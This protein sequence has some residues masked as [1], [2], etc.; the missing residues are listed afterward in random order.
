VLDAAVQTVNQLHRSDQLDFAVLTGDLINNR[1]ANELDWLVTTL[2]GGAVHPDSGADDNPL[3]GLDPHDPFVAEGLAIPWYATLGNHDRL[4][5]GHMATDA[6]IGS[7]T[8][9]R[10]RFAV[11]A[12]CV[13]TEMPVRC[14]VAHPTA[15]F[16]AIPRAI[17]ADPARRG[18]SATEVMNAMSGHGFTDGGPGYWSVKPAPKVRLIGLDTS[19][20]DG[21]TGRLDEVQ[22]AFVEAELTLADDLGEVAI[23]TSHHPSTG[24]GKWGP[25]LRRVLHRHDAVIL[26]LAGH[27]HTHSVMP[28]PGGGHGYWEVLTASLLDWPQQF[29]LVEVV[30]TG[31]GVGEIRLTVVDVA[32]TSSVV[33]DAK[34]YALHTSESGPTLFPVSGEGR[35][36]DRNV[37]LRVSLGDGFS[38]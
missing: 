26:H 23:I 14:G 5:E 9:D 33:A 2:E 38:M 10:A 21:L 20:D 13:E 16:T 22:L 29:R 35:A 1:Q 12:T 34:T 37:V 36:K 32:T 19:S 3:A 17:V 24:L 4:F 7:P 25:R 11:E 30:D 28:R 6:W 15:A 8:R 31:N 18:V 27:R